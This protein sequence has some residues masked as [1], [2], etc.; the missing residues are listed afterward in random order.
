[1]LS[2]IKKNQNFVSRDIFR[3]ECSIP[4]ND[5]ALQKSTSDKMIIL[6]VL[7]YLVYFIKMSKFCVSAKHFM[8]NG[9]NNV[10]KLLMG[11]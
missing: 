11:L 1:M 2:A 5:T 7:Q 10:F 4:N 8:E 9:N 6:N 3:K